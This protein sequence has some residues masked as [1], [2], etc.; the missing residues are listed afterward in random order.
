MEVKCYVCKQVIV[1]APETMHKGWEKMN[2][3]CTNKATI[4]F[5]L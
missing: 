3:V 1:S 2:I 4:L 5:R